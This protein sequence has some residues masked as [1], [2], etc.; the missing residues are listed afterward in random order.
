MFK[1]KYKYLH[2]KYKYEYKYFKTVLKYYSSTSTSTSTST[3]YYISAHDGAFSFLLLSQST[4][5]FCC[6]LSCR[7]SVTMTSSHICSIKRLLLT[8]YTGGQDSSVELCARH[9]RRLF[10]VFI[11]GAGPRVMPLP[12]CQAY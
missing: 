7:W 1:Y 8:F 10:L 2:L 6:I 3:K 5:Q 11:S 12:S 9:A 4:L